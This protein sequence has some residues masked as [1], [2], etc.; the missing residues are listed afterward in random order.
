MLV[1]N[2]VRQR[3]I[4][5]SCLYLDSYEQEYAIFMIR[6]QTSNSSEYLMKVELTYGNKIEMTYILK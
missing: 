5:C 3:R 6:L 4:V 2:D 1:G